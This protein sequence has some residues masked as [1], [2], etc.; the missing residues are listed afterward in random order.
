MVIPG[1]LD[2][3]VP[4]VVV[5]DAAVEAAEC[6]RAQVQRRDAASR[7]PPHMGHVDHLPSVAE[8]VSRRIQRNE[9]LVKVGEVV[10]PVDA[11]RS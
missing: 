2:R 1:R 3:K 6:R 7:C 4:L 10:Q 5:G 11:P 9:M 8:N